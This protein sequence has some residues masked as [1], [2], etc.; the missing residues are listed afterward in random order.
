MHGQ[1]PDD[2][3]L[4]SAFSPDGAQI[5]FTANWKDGTFK[6]FLLPVANGAIGGEAQSQDF[7]AA[8]ELAWRPDGGEL[9]L[10]QR[11]TTCDE[12]G[13]IVRVNTAAPNAQ[14]LLSRLDAASGSPI[15]APPAPG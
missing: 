15:W 3:V 14:T 4:S 9:A 12:R 13:R 10:A 8:C 2:Q 11:N 5:A 6:L 1:R 7:V